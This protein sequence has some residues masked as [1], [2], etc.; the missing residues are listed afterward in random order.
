MATSQ[1]FKYDVRSEQELYEDIIIESLQFYGQDVYYL[2]REV[3]TNEDIFD[4]EVL[5]RF[6]HAYKIEMYVENID[7]FDG[8]GDLFSKFGIEIRDAC[9]F[10]VARK[11]FNSEIGIH[12]G[13]GTA[14]SF[15]RPREGDIIHLPLSQSTFEIMRVEPEN[16]FF[17]VGHLPVFKMRC[18]LF[19]YSGEDFNTKVDQIDAIE[20]FSAYQY[21]LT[22]DSASVGY[23]IGETVSQIDS[24]YTLSGKVVA[25]SDSD[26]KL[27]LSQV[28]STDAK[29]HTFTTT[30]VVVGAESLAVATPT[31]IEELQKIQTEPID[32][33]VKALEFVDFSEEN[34]F[35]DPF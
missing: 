14:P 5:S 3:V 21:V 8:D 35:G 20:G 31:L 28:G 23:E 7:G 2:P 19:E 25:W 6:A 30:D 10:V 13:D 24:D 22:M 12:A 27:Y 34:P 16:P 9:T 11:R 32:F 1:Y 33:D 29:Y 15:Y 17:Q 18:E 26:N 4:D